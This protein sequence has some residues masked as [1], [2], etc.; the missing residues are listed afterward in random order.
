M[1]P[2]ASPDSNFVGLAAEEQD[3]EVPPTAGAGLPPI[4]GA[5]GTGGGRSRLGSVLEEAFQGGVLGSVRG[6]LWY[7][8]KSSHALWLVDGPLA[9]RIGHC[10]K[11]VE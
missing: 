9:H 1:T 4:R 8:G 5:V 11:G 7:R 3:A 10:V 6:G 2:A